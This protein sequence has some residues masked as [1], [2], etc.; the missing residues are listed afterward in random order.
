MQKYRN[1]TLVTLNAVIFVCLSA[2]YYGLGADR[3][4]IG[5]VAIR[6]RGSTVQSGS[7]MVT[8]AIT[9][10][11]EFPIRFAAVALTKEGTQSWRPVYTSR[12]SITLQRGQIPARDT[13]IF[14]WAL[15]PTNR[16]KIEVSYNDAR[17][18][19]KGRVQGTV[20]SLEMEGGA[21][22]PPVKR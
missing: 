21:L 19:S 11:F 8:F 4:Q 10:A 7:N 3:D 22:I 9:N 18:L 1:R 13:A 12:A 15:P 5:D 20:S 16:W 2:F 14:A 17:S 6:I